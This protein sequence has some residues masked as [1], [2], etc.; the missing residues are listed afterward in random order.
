MK[1]K[2]ITSLLILSVAL[3][4]SQVYEVDQLSKKVSTIENQVA[5]IQ[6]QILA[7]QMANDS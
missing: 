1:R 7:F 2:F 4:H 5:K 3:A 6:E